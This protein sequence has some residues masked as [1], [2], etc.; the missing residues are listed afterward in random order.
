MRRFLTLFC[1]EGRQPEHQPGKKEFSG[2]CRYLK[3]DDIYVHAEE[4]GA[5]TTVVKNHRPGKPV[6]PVSLNQAGA[7]AVCRSKAWDAKV[8]TPAWWVHAHQVCFAT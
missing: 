7:S 1:S 6:S 2:V 4:H 3:K 5:A 8:T